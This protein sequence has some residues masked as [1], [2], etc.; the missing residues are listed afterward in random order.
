[1]SEVVT[2]SWR[3]VWHILISYQKGFAHVKHLEKP[4]TMPSGIVKGSQKNFTKGLLKRWNML[5]LEVDM[6]LT[7]MDP[8]DIYVLGAFINAIKIRTRKV[9]EL[10]PTTVGNVERPN[11]STTILDRLD[12]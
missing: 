7:S 4:Q 2:K 1:M 6:I 8:K 3:I 12:I 9:C 5:P 10:T 11:Q